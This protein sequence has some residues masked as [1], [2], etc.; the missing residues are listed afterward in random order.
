MVTSSH[1]HTEAATT[2][3]VTHSEMTCR[4][5]DRA[6]AENDISRRPPSGRAA[7]LWEA[8]SPLCHSVWDP[9]QKAQ[10]KCWGY[11]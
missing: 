7:G 11:T 4:L 8:G 6:S 2:C 1:R 3:D 9:A 5:R 10:C